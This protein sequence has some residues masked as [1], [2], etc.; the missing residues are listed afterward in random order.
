MG[1]YIFRSEGREFLGFTLIELLAVI[2]V[3]S[4]LLALLLPAVQAARSAAQRLSCSS[5]MRQIGIAIHS[6]NNVHSRFPPSKWGTENGS[7]PP[8]H[9]ILTFLLPYLELQDI[10]DEVNFSDHW[11]SVT[12]YSATK[13]EL[14]IFQCPAAP[15]KN[16]YNNII[17]YVSDYA[18]AEKIRKTA[19]HIE[20]LFKN[21]IVLSRTAEQ[22]RGLLRP[23]NESL[24]IESVS[25]GLSN[26]MMFFECSARPFIYGLHWRFDSLKTP[27]EHRYE[28]SAD[29]A[30]NK[31]PFYIGEVCG[32]GK[33]QLMNCTNNEEIYSFH[34]GGANFLFGDN[35]VRFI[36]ESIHPEQFISLFTAIAG[37]V[38]TLP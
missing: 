27:P 34:A 22:L 31:S 14:S 10:Y 12:N 13:R 23:D 20:P 5:K 9:N 30:S 3:I 21:S 18:V 36:G 38:A 8:R 33:M 7:K 16:T 15:R 1:R 19:N 32:E 2:A 26:T 24:N 25:D 4:L 11:S 17:Y 6:Y 35:A 28:S 37:D 29:W